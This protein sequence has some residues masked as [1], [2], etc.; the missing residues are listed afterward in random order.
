MYLIRLVRNN[1]YDFPI[2]G[3]GAKSMFKEKSECYTDHIYDFGINIGGRLAIYMGFA[4]S[5]LA[6]G[7]KYTLFYSYSIQV[8]EL[9]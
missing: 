9:L 5:L 8:T 1:I 6:N 4:K 7:T 3:F 2:Y